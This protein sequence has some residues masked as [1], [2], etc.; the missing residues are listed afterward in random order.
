MH[1]DTDG[2]VPGNALVVSFKNHWSN[3]S[4]LW[5]TIITR[6][7]PR[8]SSDL[9]ASLATLS[10]I[11]GALH[12]YIDSLWILSPRPESLPCSWLNLSPF[13]VPVLWHQLSGSTDLTKKIFTETPLAGFER[14]LHRGHAWH[15]QW[16][17]T[18]NRWEG[19]CGGFSDV[20]LRG[21]PSIG[22]PTSQFNWPFAESR[23]LSRVQCQI[24]PRNNPFVLFCVQSSQ[25]LD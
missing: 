3:N 6:W 22:F 10:W 14:H 5:N 23:C 13:Q 1:A 24:I 11:G 25:I 17:E 15:P 12:Q 20:L 7:T 9:S 18:K 21:S 4:Q 8:N 16:R 2:I 19:G